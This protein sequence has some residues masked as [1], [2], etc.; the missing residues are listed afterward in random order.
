MSLP[1]GRSGTFGVAYVTAAWRDIRRDWRDL[2]PGLLG[3]TVASTVFLVGGMLAFAVGALLDN[4]DGSRIGMA[5]ALGATA[6]GAAGLLLPWD[7]WARSTQLVFP[8]SGLVLLALGGVSPT[9]P[10]PAFLAILP[11]PFVFVGFTQRPGISL[12]LAPLTGMLLLAASGFEWNGNLLATLMFAVPMSVLVGEAIAQA[13]LHRKHAEEHLERLL[14]AV[15]VLAHVTDER[16]GARLVAAL[17]T[18]LLN[19]DAVAVLLADR[20]RST[21]YLNR[22]WFGH[23]A[24]ADAAPLLVDALSARPGLRPGAM[25]F[26]AD[27][28]RDPMIAAA[29]G[30]VRAAALLPMPGAGGVP[31]G[32]VIAMWATPRRGLPAPARQAAE[33]LSQ[34]AGRMFQRVQQTAA[35]ARDAETD[36]LT[37]LAN[38]RTFS[39][40]LSTLQAGDAVVIV[41]L[42]HFKSVNDRFG[43]Q[44]GDET[45]RALA[46]CLRDVTRQVDCVARYGGE[47]FALV[48]PEARID[49]ARKALAR[50]RATWN[51]LEPIT[52]FSSGIAVRADD[53][54]PRETLR[55][56]DAAL[57]EA[58]EAGRDRDVVAPDR[59]IVLP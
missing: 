36:P 10:F 17:A 33:L 9:G 20:P 5:A 19:A 23:P 12:A 54:S 4:F 41:D 7:R 11:L 32:V 53:E 30:R 24:L 38:R 3:P 26:V 49:G 34:E 35:L 58:K 47:E 51:A 22:A 48:L 46:R 21:R 18:E 56:A 13:Q 45:L 37:E 43:H 39:R 8:V 14:H 59:E 2:D 55:R 44:V 1:I 25:R 57:Y 16:T 42:D 27:P 52:S 40:A 6:I 31:L 28:A 50:A 29:H 15:R